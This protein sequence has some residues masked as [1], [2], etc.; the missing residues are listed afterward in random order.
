M[1]LAET[2]DELERL[3]VA[4]PGK[5]ITGLSRRS[6]MSARRLTKLV[7]MLQ[8]AGRVEIRNTYEPEFDNTSWRVWPLA[9]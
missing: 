5:S 7:V 4:A 3:I 9:Q 8:E 1:S 2:F 6:G